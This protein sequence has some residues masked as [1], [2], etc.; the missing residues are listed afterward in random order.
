MISPD[1]CHL[2]EP[3]VYHPLIGFAEHSGAS[4][5]IA[6]G[7]GDL[8]LVDCLEDGQQRRAGRNANDTTVDK[9]PPAAVPRYPAQQLP[10]TRWRWEAGTPDDNLQ[11]GGALR[12]VDFGHGH[13]ET[14]TVN[15]LGR[16]RLVP[17]AKG[18]PCLQRSV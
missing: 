1:L 13:R 18:M 2:S 11:C 16:V 9:H 7:L 10:R 17:A 14:L 5:A 8:H 3:K 4:L 12:G 15:Y 6:Q